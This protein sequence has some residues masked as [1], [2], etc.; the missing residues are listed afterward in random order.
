MPFMIHTKKEEKN[1]CCFFPFSIARLYSTS[2]L[3]MMQNILL[4][5]IGNYFFR[6]SR[7][8]VCLP[9]FQIL[10]QLLTCCVIGLQLLKSILFVQKSQ[11]PFYEEV[12]NFPL[13]VYN[14]LLLQFINTL[15]LF[16]IDAFFCWSNIRGVFYSISNLQRK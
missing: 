7:M 3:M 5:C 11:V 10:N 13:R 6:I 1:V 14:Y 12:S 2:N 8:S 9:H 15:P 16:C 4:H